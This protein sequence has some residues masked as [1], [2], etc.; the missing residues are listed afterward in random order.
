MPPEQV[1]L[2]IVGTIVILFGAYYVTYFVGMKASGQTRA[3]MR[4]RNISLLDRY[5]ISRDKQFCIVEIAG[6][7]Y[8]VGVTNHTMTLLD[9]FDAAVFAELTESK[10]DS[11][12]PWRMTPVGQ[13]GNRL[14]RKVVE[15]IAAK[16]GKRQVYE[17]KTGTADFTENMKTAE[18][19]A[20][21]SNNEIPTSTEDSNF[22]DFPSLPE[23]PENPVE[24]ETVEKTSPEDQP[25]ST[26]GD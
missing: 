24:K 18:Q 4:N 22:P 13:Y 11:V 23:L 7:V 21:K 10:E 1:I 12:T 16:T 6:K 19:N 26:E 2:F 9:T 20:D 8:V 25:D 17:S 5:A 15:F 14:T 3:G